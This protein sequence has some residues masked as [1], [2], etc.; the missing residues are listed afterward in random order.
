MPKTHPHRK[1]ILQPRIDVID[2]DCLV[3]ERRLSIFLD[4][5]TA[6]N[7]RAGAENVAH[8]FS[9]CLR[10]VVRGKDVRVRIA[11]T[12]DVAIE[13]P[14]PAR[15]SVEEPVVGARGY[16]INRIVRAH[17]RGHFALLNA[18]LERRHVAVDEI[19]L[20]HLGVELLAVVLVALAVVGGLHTVSNVVFAARRGLDVRRVCRVV[21]MNLRKGEKKRKREGC[22]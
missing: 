18:V 5:A 12:C 17:Q 11:V 16:A 10:V 13:L 19:L 1:E 22:V 21:L 6:V 3:I 9:W 2:S 14:L 8:R 20:S 4:K 7:V 15:Y